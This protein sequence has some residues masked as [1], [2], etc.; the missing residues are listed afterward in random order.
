[1]KLRL[2]VISLLLC[3]SSYAFSMEKNIFFLTYGRSTEMGASLR[4]DVACMVPHIQE[5]CLKNEKK[6][7]H[8]PDATKN[9]IKHLEEYILKRFHIKTKTSYYYDPEALWYLHAKKLDLSDLIKLTKNVCF[10]Y[11]D[12]QVPLGL[13]DPLVEKM[14]S[15]TLKKFHEYVPLL[16]NK[17][18]QGNIIQKIVN[19]DLKRNQNKELLSKSVS[20]ESIITRLMEPYSLALEKSTDLPSYHKS[21]CD[22]LYKSFVKHIYVGNKITV[23][24]VGAEQIQQLYYSHR[25]YILT[26]HTSSGSKTYTLDDKALNFHEKG[27]FANKD[28]T[29]FVCPYND[30]FESQGDNTG[31]LFVIDLKNDITQKIACLYKAYGFNENG[32]ILAFDEHG[33]SYYLNNAHVWKKNGSFGQQAIKG[34]V[35]SDNN[36]IYWTSSDVYIEKR[37]D[38]SKAWGVNGESISD[39]IINSQGTKACIKTMSRGEMIEN[40][41]SSDDMNYSYYLYDCCDQ[42]IKHVKSICEKAF[43]SFSSDGNLLI[44]GSCKDGFIIYDIFDTFSLRFWRKQS[45]GELVALGNDKSIEVTEGAF[46]YYPRCVTLIDETMKNAL[47]AITYSN[48][49]CNK[50]DPLEITKALLKEDST[51]NYP[52]AIK[53]IRS[54]SPLV[55]NAI[56]KPQQ[57]YYLWST[58]CDAWQMFKSSKSIM[59]AT[60]LAAMAGIYKLIK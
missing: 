37:G 48:Y 7:L 26:I 16:P 47:E 15:L 31:G 44:I 22:L 57:G 58:L 51:F 56:I 54:G 5:E 1:M 41:R 33:N 46:S 27:S 19:I 21:I 52:G 50:T 20:G 39:V 30:P 10:L 28:E 24:L 53:I 38:I 13:L 8:F 42:S 29:I 9:D 59:A 45:T 49:S 34:C 40:K 25:N 43:A 18:L 17:T 32:E 4:L 2:L 36:R 12:E 35:F 14:Q 55:Q 11:P 23:Y 6:W 3:V 60:L